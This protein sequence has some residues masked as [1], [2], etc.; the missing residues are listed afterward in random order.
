MGKLQEDVRIDPILKEVIKMPAQ[1]NSVA[2]DV[3]TL[4]ADFNSLLQ[5]LRD[6]GLMEG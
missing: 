3:A 6:A 1:D 5:K 2:A 4:V